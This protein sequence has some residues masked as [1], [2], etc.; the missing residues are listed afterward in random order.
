MYLLLSRC[1]HG[2]PYTAVM[3]VLFG[4]LSVIF[5]KDHME[6]QYLPFLVQQWLHIND[7]IILLVF[8]P[9]LLY[10][11]S[12]MVDTHIFFGALGQILTFTFPMVLGGPTLMAVVLLYMTP[13]SLR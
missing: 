1:A 7:L 11:D 9:G 12:F 2:I 8:L 4:S 6:H 10:L 5:L 3:F 13:L